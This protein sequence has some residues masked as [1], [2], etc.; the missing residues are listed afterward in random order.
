MPRPTDQITQLA[1]IPASP[2]DS[3]TSVP[4]S[5]TASDRLAVPNIAM[6]GFTNDSSHQY[7]RLELPRSIHGTLF[8]CADEDGV[9]AGWG[10]ESVQPVLQQLATVNA[11]GAKSP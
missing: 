10:A 8:V 1:K 7:S 3:A 5:R 4:V 9:I 2:S 11:A 6:R